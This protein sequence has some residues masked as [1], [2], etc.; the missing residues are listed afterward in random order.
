M[1]K[2]EMN[3]WLDKAATT[4]INQWYRKYNLPTMQ[5]NSAAVYH[6][7]LNQKGASK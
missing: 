1:E 3:S 2:T 4:N 7:Y 6:A 5:V